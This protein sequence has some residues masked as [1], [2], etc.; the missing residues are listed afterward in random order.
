M[1]LR[2]EGRGGGYGRR[3]GNKVMKEGRAGKNVMEGGQGIR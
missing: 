2:R 3:A 1:K